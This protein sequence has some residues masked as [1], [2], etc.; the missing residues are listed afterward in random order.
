MGVK[1]GRQCFKSSSALLFLWHETRL[2]RHN[3]HPND[4][5]HP[6]LSPPPHLSDCRDVWGGHTWAHACRCSCSSAGGDTEGA[7]RVQKQR[8]G[9][10]FLEQAFDEVSSYY[11]LLLSSVFVCIIVS[12]WCLRGS[13]WHAKVPHPTVSHHWV[14]PAEW[15]LLLAVT[16]P[17]EMRKLHH[18][19]TII[20]VH[21]YLAYVLLIPGL[22]VAKKNLN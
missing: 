10:S 22:S 9:G 19:S 18:L 14:H 21:I 13:V 16:R 15:G 17:L 20:N 7:E 3:L 6:C 11:R 1:R 4:R 8:D 5:K 12:G 2:R